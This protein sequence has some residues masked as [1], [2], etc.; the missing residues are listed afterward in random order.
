MNPAGVRVDLAPRAGESN[1][2]KRILWRMTLR[3]WRWL[4]ILALAALVAGYWT[5]AGRLIHPVPYG[6]DEADYLR[7]ASMG[8]AANYTDARSISMGEFT[9]IGLGAGRDA[10]RK[11]ELSS[12]IRKRGDVL[13]LRHWHGPLYYF[14]IIAAEGR[15]TR[16][17]QAMRRLLLGIPAL[18]FLLVWFGLRSLLSG[19]WGYLAGG[20]FG[21]FY[22]FSYSSLRTAPM[23]AP[24]SLFVLWCLAVAI[25]LAKFVDTGRLRYWYGAVAGCALALAT[26]EVGVPLVAVMAGVCLLERARVFR[27]W[28][29]DEWLRFT[30][31]SAGLF[32]AV[33]TAVWPAAIFKLSVMKAWAFMAY[34]SAF[35]KAA[36][37]DVT[38]ADSWVERL[39]ASP[40]EWLL[41]AA[42]LAAFFRWRSKLSVAVPAL[43]VG[44]VMLASVLRVVSTDY[45]Y[46]TVYL[47]AFHLFGSIVLAQAALRLGPRRAGAAVALACAVLLWNS[48]RQVRP[49]TAE[50]HR[51]AWAVIDLLRAEDIKGRRVLVPATLAP[52]L[53]FYFPDTAVRGYGSAAEAGALKASGNFDGILVVRPEPAFVRL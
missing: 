48:N 16:D 10:A 8:F 21:F 31:Q 27:D 22:L 53:Q 6:Y 40:A 38:F 45:R 36:W 42:A 51:R 25:L 34:L 47:P 44:A 3:R 18:T 5:W 30:A 32:V 14:G 41:L 17:E 20:L 23:L 37:G 35:R 43:L 29:R 11:S 24:H 13:F 19:A 49:W 28:H 9:E 2:R 52:T 33:L 26:L 12:S 15:L 4:E 50:D 1:R 46:M 39:A 7:A